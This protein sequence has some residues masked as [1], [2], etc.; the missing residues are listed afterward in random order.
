MEER[1][2][3]FISLVSDSL[4]YS[5]IDGKELKNYDVKMNLFLSDNIKS[6][7]DILSFSMYLSSLSN[8]VIKRESFYIIKKFMNG[9]TFLSE[10]EIVKLYFEDDNFYYLANLIKNYDTSKISN[11]ITEY[12]FKKLFEIYSLKTFELFSDGLLNNINLELYVK[13]PNLTEENLRILLNYYTLLSPKTISNILNRYN[14]F[15]SI[16]DIDK[17]L[18]NS[19]DGTINYS[20]P[21]PYSFEERLKIYSKASESSFKN[22]VKEEDLSKIIENVKNKKYNEIP[23]GVKVNILKLFLK[24]NGNM[25]NNE[26][27]ISLLNAIDDKS[28]T[29][30]FISLYD[31]NKLNFILDRKE[32][33]V[34]ISEKGFEL[35]INSKNISLDEKLKLF[36]YN[37]PQNL[38]LFVQNNEV[39]DELFFKLAETQKFSLI[40]LKIN[41]KY[42]TKEKAKLLLYNSFYY[43]QINSMTLVKLINLLDKHEAVSILNNK[44][45]LFSIGS[46]NLAYIMSIDFKD[47][48]NNDNIFSYYNKDLLNDTLN[49]YLDVDLSVLCNKNISSLLFNKKNL[50]NENDIN[51]LKYLLEYTKNINREPLKVDINTIKSFVPMYL[52]FGIEGSIELISLSMDNE[53]KAKDIIKM[54][55]RLLQTRINIF[56]MNNAPLFNGAYDILMYYL[57]NPK[58]E[59][60]VSGARL[61]LYNYINSTNQEFKNTVNEY[62]RIKDNPNNT[63]KINLL[64][65]KIRENINKSIKK[66]CE[67]E[68][69]KINEK[70]MNKIYTFFKIKDSTMKKMSD[71]FKKEQGV[72]TM[73]G[74]L[75]NIMNST[76]KKDILKK[77]IITNEIRNKLNLD[78]LCSYEYFE[79]NMFKMLLNS[80]FNRELFLENL[81]YS[82]PKNYS[83][84]LN[85]KRLNK[86]IEQINKI[87]IKNKDKVFEY[88]L[89]EDI[90]IFEYVD[91]NLIKL[92]KNKKHIFREYVNEMGYNNE[93]LY[94]KTIKNYD[95]T[96]C[97]HYEF[98]NDKVKK[99]GKDIFTIMQNIL[100]SK[101]LS[102]DFDEI[103]NSKVAFNNENFEIKRKPLKI[104]EI[105]TLFSNF[106]FNIK[107][108]EDNNELIK[109]F[110]FKNIYNIR[111]IEEPKETEYYTKNLG[112]ILSHYDKLD[113]ICQT[114]NIDINNI[115]IEEIKTLQDY[116]LLS[117]TPFGETIDKKI[118]SKVINETEFIEVTDLTKR[119][120]VAVDLLE[121]A[122][123][124]ISGTIPLITTPNYEIVDFHNSSNLISGYINASCF[125]AGGVG[126]DFITYCMLN[127][128]GAIIFIKNS[129]TGEILGRISAIR[130]GNVLFMHQL[131]INEKYNYNKEIKLYCEKEIKLLSDEI[132]NFTSNTNEPIEFVTITKYGVFEGELKNNEVLTSSECKY[133]EE[134]IDTN[135]PDY[136][137]FLKYNYLNKSYIYPSFY[138]NYGSC[139]TI[140]VSQ[141][142]DKTKKDIKDYSAK[143]IYKRQRKNI[144]EYQIIS[145]EAESKLKSLLY[146]Y[147]KKE[148]SKEEATI[149]AKIFKTKDIINL[150][151]G[152]DWCI[153]EYKDGTIESFDLQYDERSVIE[154]EEYINYCDKEGVIRI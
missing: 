73:M 122:Q 21:L 16:I 133:V 11:Y 23:N 36:E 41:E 143:E 151:I 82:K 61:N 152:E 69:N 101:N 74:E 4:Y 112:Y 56:R 134:P 51:S 102:I 17:M 89:G 24:D 5:R 52:T 55:D 118:I 77:Q 104:S 39:N 142:K 44:E 32:F 106:D 57:N 80:K 68:S 31:K 18:P 132:I 154:K 130:R 84:F 147:Y 113:S 116:I 72:R 153:I 110:V 53:I 15:S 12:N 123:K 124:R 97:I 95:E 76:N 100:N 38:N 128:N 40:K 91:T 2:K 62:L 66:Y 86:E 88:L 28:I 63:E 114:L 25:L 125:R 60:I 79:E 22:I 7:E 71:K 10:E 26:D 93:G 144:L 3:N 120:E 149:R 64:K 136:K 14:D 145:K 65:D 121:E 109:N 27:I 20:F 85:N 150:K 117:L 127:K 137:E 138:H 48:I 81:G 99:A 107:D 131:Q 78:N 29:F 140:V 146:L 1:Y 70:L 96:S 42:L 9:L 59:R 94:Y 35:L 135:S 37:I 111:L 105:K 43:S 58:L 92:I 139:D 8:L 83:L 87:F 13:D 49:Y 90:N 148:Y 46:D 108:Y 30:V 54:K 19:L 45:I 67:E 6:Y 47:I 75:Y 103:D 119:V 141:A 129:D 115:T 50:L 34:K 33:Y 126:N 98:L